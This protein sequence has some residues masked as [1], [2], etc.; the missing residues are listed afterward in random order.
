MRT[1]FGSG[2][3]VARTGWPLALQRLATSM[4]STTRQHRGSRKHFLGRCALYLCVQRGGSAAHVALV[5]A[6]SCIEGRNEDTDGELDAA[7][8][9]SPLAITSICR[10]SCRR[11]AMLRSRKSRLAATV[12]PASLQMRAAA[13]LRGMPR[14]RRSPTSGQAAR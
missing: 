1:V 14:P 6:A 4:A 5:R 13:R 9:G 11:V 12:A 3:G 8:R 7:Q 10:S 2:R